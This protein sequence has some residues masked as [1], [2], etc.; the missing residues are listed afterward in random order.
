MIAAKNSPENKALGRN[1]AK[2]EA[3]L[4]QLAHAGRLVILCSLTECE[5]TV[6]QLVELVDLS[7]SAV[8]QHLAKLREADL[9]ESDKRGQMVF[10]R[11][12]SKEV[13]AIISTL[14][15]IYCKP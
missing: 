9:V 4:K 12:K 8:S 6:G 10:Y 15:R 1:A 2:A 13:Q 3:M 5:K 11:L 7:Q 14:Y